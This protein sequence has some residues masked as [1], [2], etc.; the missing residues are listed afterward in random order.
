[1]RLKNIQPMNQASVDLDEYCGMH[2]RITIFAK[3]ALYV[4]ESMNVVRLQIV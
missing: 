1:M 4:E 3:M 2:Q